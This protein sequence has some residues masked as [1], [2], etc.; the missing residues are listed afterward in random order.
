MTK[1]VDRLNTKAILKNCALLGL[2]AKT[3]AS[4]L[5][6][7]PKTISRWQDGSAHP[8]AA[9]LRSLEKLAGIRRLASH[10][11]PRPRGT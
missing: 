6:V 4:C 10:G 5:A 7:N 8:N 2:D 11:T 3:L 9:G 1:V